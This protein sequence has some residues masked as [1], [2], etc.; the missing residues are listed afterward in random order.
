MESSE[1]RF[2]LDV[3]GGLEGG[4]KSVSEIGERLRGEGGGLV[5]I[6]YHPCEWVHKEFWD[7][8]NFR[9]GANPPRDQ[10]KAPPQRTAAE[11]DA[12]F[13]RVGKYVDFIKAMDGVRVVTA[14]ELP[15]RYPDRARTREVGGGRRSGVAGGGGSSAGGASGARRGRAR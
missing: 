11:T 14:R 3:A 2:E 1:T 10:W 12:A 15:G 9:R 5:S 6:F 7:G 4:K 8:V 13:E